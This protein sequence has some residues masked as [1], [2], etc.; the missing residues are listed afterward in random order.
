MTGSSASGTYSSL[1]WSGGTGLGTWT[2]NA[3]PALAVFTPSVPS[4]SFTATL[5]V[6]GT[7]ACTGT[8]PSDSRLITW[9][10]TPV[11]IA[12]PD[13][14]RCDLN[15]LA[16]IAMTGASS[17][18]TYSS[19]IWT[20]GTGLGTW[21]QNAN[22]ALATFTPSVSYGTFTA[23]LTLTGT[24]AC[25]G[26]NSVVTRLVEWSHAA[27]VNAGPDQS[28]CANASV[29]LAGSI[30]GAATSAVWT[31][32]TGTFVPDNTTLNAVYT[33][34]AAEKAAHTVTLTLTTNDPAGI[35]PA[36][37][38]DITIEI[39]TVPSNAVLTTSGD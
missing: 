10:Q 18:G 30:G 3:D 1:S 33:P 21:T 22:P 23:T 8:N 31:G 35:C 11:A 34:S 4:G 15:P 16:P 9:G 25:S 13:I 27:T 20:G 32:G 2:Q 29:N 5:S 24:G 26:S 14:S 38:D 37:S 12:G 36:V 39:G 28:I 19:Q 6:T 17:S 7:G